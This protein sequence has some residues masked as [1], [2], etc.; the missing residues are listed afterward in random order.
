MFVGGDYQFSILN[1]VGLNIRCA[2]CLN[3]DKNMNNS[4]NKLSDIKNSVTF[5]I[6][7]RG[8]SLIM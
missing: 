3:N 7:A 5:S 4:K 2:I 1:F 6:V 8:T